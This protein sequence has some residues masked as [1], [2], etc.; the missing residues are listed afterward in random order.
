[1]SR[2]AAMAGLARPIASAANALA[3]ANPRVNLFI[4]VT[5]SSGLAELSNC[6]L[7]E[8]AMG[9]R[10]SVVGPI[11]P[12]SQAITA[13]AQVWSESHSAESSAKAKSGGVALG[14]LYV[15]RLVSV[16]TRNP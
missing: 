4:F 5:P 9:C 1:M 15:Q 6:Y 13:S 2:G 14:D 12:G 7:L 16:T 11:S 10:S 8:H 3:L